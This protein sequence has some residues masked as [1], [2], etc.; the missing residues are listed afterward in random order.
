[1]IKLSDA[2]YERRRLDQSVGRP[3]HSARSRLLCLVQTNNLPRL[4]LE[5]AHS[6]PR[7]ALKLATSIV[8]GDGS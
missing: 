3:D 7:L 8:R 2:P 6:P 4:R 1:M 5:D